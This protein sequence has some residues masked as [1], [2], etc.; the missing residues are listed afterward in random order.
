MECGV[1]QGCPISPLLFAASIDVLLRYIIH[2]LK[3]RDGV[4]VRGTIRA[5]ADDIGAV[6]EDWDRDGPQLEAIFREFATMSGLELN[7]PK[8]IAIPLWEQ[9]LPDIKQALGIAIPAWRD[10]AVQGKGTYLGFAVGPSSPGNS[11]DKA[12]TKYASRCRVWGSMGTGLQFSTTAYNTFCASTL[13]F[14]GQLVP[15]TDEIRANEQ[16]GIRHLLSGPGNWIDRQDPFHLKSSFGQKASFR[17]IT[18]V[19]EASMLRVKFNHDCQRRSE[20][21]HR[22]RLKDIAAMANNIRCWSQASIYPHRAIGWKNWYAHSF[23]LVLHDNEVS[24]CAKCR[25]SPE[26]IRT[27]IAGGPQPWSCEVREKQKR[28]FQTTAHALILEHIRP[29]PINRIRHKITRWSENVNNCVGWGLP[30]N[31]N[32]T[33]NRIHFNLSRLHTLVAPRVCAAAF[34]TVFNGWCTHHRFQRRHWATNICVFGCSCSASDSLEHY[35]RCPVVLEVLQ[36]KLRVKITP[37]AALRLFVLDIPRSED[38]LL[39]CGALINYAVYTTFNTFRVKGTTR[40]PVVSADALGQALLNAVMGHPASEE[41]LR[42][43]WAAGE[44]SGPVHPADF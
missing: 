30:D 4:S 17:N 16:I 40:T 19:A 39:M 12:L 44:S 29:E 13:S 25:S 33:S 34:R 1:R 42:N 11:W 20:G 22:T 23:A 7:I 32:V 3:N 36:R 27:S 28:N 14:I 41:F 10:I 8:T 2:S 37:R 6:I 38:D 26:D 24:F 21:T 15:V 35:C 9:P 43:R 5:F 31:I 18:S